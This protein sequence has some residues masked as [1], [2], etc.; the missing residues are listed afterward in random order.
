VLRWESDTTSASPYTRAYVA[1]MWRARDKE[2]FEG[3]AHT[4]DE[5]MQRQS[6][7]NQP[8]TRWTRW[9]ARVDRERSSDLLLWRVRPRRRAPEA[10]VLYLHGGG[11]IHP[12]TK[13][14][15]RLV[16]ALARTPAEVVLPAYPLAPV[17]KVDD[18]L[19]RLV[20]LAEDLAQREPRLP[21]VLMGDSAGGALVLA[22]ALRLRD[23]RSVTPAGLVCLSPWLDVTLGEEEVGRLESSDP[24]LS[25]SGLRA[26]GKWWA[27]NRDPLDPL[28][29]PVGADLRGLPPIDVFI[30][31]RDILRPAVETMAERVRE[32]DTDV[33]V[34]EVSAMFHVWMTR[35]I[36]EARAT[37]K[38]LRRLVQRRAADADHP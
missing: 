30:G 31:D 27:G 23:R 28:V 4:L 37:R 33:T 9:R 6:S 29:S 17:A 36:P 32:I 7:G 11:Y 34:H 15:W 19:P 16:R 24:M 20:E 13:D 5:A 12:L 25:E 21:L 3:S 38:T 26:A 18:V 14:Y 1:A 22:I 8:P 2:A 10:R 35:A